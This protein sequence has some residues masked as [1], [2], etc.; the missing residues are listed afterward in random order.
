MS[1]NC[2]KLGVIPFGVA[3]GSTW[4]MGLLIFG[5]ISWLSGWGLAMISLIGSVYI[6][7]SATFWGAIVGAIWGFV[8]AFIGGIIMAAI[9]NRCICNDKRVTQTE[10]V[11]VL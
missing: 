5:W 8:D 11:E 1:N 4:A 2:A 10:T 7:Y 6:G 3:F 9:Y